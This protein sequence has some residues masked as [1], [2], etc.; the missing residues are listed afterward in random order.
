MPV[1]VTWTAEML[2]ELP[3]SRGEAIKN[4]STH[5]FNGS[6]CKANQH[7]CPRLTSSGKCVY[8]M[9]NRRRTN[10]AAK[11]PK[12]QSGQSKTQRATHG[13]SKS[14]AQMLYNTAKQRARRK[15][16]KFDIS[17][18]DILV[19]ERCPVFDTLLNTTWGSAK[20]NNADRMNVATLDRVNPNLGYVK[21]NVAVI[22]YRAN[23]LKGAGTA[24]EHRK[25][26]IFL[27]QI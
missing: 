23:M 10:T 6:L 22:S 17:V 19:P 27:Q 7:L 14:Y 20:Q 9:R 21:G 26:G 11:S 25:I 13:L 12:V 18:E 15:G 3:Q 16:F 24:E 2:E 1:K 4:N 5:Y 8:C